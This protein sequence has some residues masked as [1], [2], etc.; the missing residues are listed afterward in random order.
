MHKFCAC[1]N[2]SEIQKKS[3]NYPPVAG[4]GGG[5]AYFRHWLKFLRFLI[6]MPPLSILP[7]VK[8]FTFV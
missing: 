2:K 4:G 7:L 5:Q 3:L 1:L 6:M 8:V